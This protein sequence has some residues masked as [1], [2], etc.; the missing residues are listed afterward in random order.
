M[1]KEY[2]LTIAKE[3]TFEQLPWQCNPKND[4][5]NLASRAWRPVFE[6]DLCG[7]NPKRKLGGRYVDPTRLKASLKKNGDLRWTQNMFQDSIGK[8]PN[9]FDYVLFVTS[10]DP[11]SSATPWLFTGPSGP[12]KITECEPVL[13]VRGSKTY[14]EG[15]LNTRNKV[16]ELLDFKGRETKPRWLRTITPSG[17]DDFV[18]PYRG[19]GDW[20][21]SDERKFEWASAEI[22]SCAENFIEEELRGKRIKELK[23]NM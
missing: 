22:K 15:V 14:Y 8:Q 7:A 17:Y 11:K 3:Y 19:S 5:L 10:R 23:Y 1:F 18:L 21:N 16:L 2:L 9:L 20:L 12:A 4:A 6:I 13:S